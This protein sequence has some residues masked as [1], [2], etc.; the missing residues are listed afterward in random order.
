MSTRSTRPQTVGEMRTAI[1]T[2]FGRP[3]PAPRPAPTPP[4]PTVVPTRDAELEHR[5]QWYE[6]KFPWM[7]GK[8]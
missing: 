5:R 3:A 7:K 6:A 1:R 8:L 2:A 4:Q